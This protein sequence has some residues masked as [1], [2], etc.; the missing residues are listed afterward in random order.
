MVEAGDTKLHARSP[1]DPFALTSQCT[2]PR[3]LI[4]S[5]LCALILLLNTHRQNPGTYPPHPCI[6]RFR[7]LQPISFD[8]FH[9]IRASFMPLDENSGLSA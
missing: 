7:I 4:K 5:D 6:P 9:E 3:L 2:P 1:A 8:K